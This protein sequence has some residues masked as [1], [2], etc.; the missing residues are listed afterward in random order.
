MRVDLNHYCLQL[1][2]SVLHQAE[3]WG[4]RFAMVGFVVTIAAISLK[5]AFYVLAMQNALRFGMESAKKNLGYMQI[6]GLRLWLKLRY[7]LCELDCR[8]FLDEFVPTQIAQTVIA[9]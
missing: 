8:F 4:S 9:A 1:L 2:I 5:S 7:G 6:R 3:R